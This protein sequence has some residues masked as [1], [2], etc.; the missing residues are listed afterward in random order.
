MIYN[1]NANIVY[2]YILSIADKPLFLFLSDD[3]ALDNTL[4]KV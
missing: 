4:S 2:I 3:C 1:T